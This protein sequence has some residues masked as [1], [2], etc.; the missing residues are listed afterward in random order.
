[1]KAVQAFPKKRRGRNTN[2]TVTV[3]I[4]DDHNFDRQIISAHYF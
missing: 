3:T 1:M 4:S 2:G